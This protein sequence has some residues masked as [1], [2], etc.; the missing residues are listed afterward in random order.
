MEEDKELNIKR[1]ETAFDELIKRGLKLVS[2]NEMLRKAGMGPQQASNYKN[3]KNIGAEIAKKLMNAYRL[4]PSYIQF[5]ELPVIL[6]PGI[7][8]HSAKADSNVFEGISEK[9]LPEKFTAL[10][11][12]S[13]R[14]EDLQRYIKRMEQNLDDKEKIIKLLEREK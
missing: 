3:G 14:I 9:A 12:M 11:Q 1:L 10:H 2:V 4:N 13:E 7:T 6:E 8:S 5:G